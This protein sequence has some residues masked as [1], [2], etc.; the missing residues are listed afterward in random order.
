MYLKQNH[1]SR[2]LHQRNSY[3]RQWFLLDEHLISC[4]KEKSHTCLN[5]LVCTDIFHRTPVR[6]AAFFPL[7]VPFRLATMKQESHVDKSLLIRWVSNVEEESISVGKPYSTD[8]TPIWLL[9]GLES[10]FQQDCSVYSTL[11]CTHQ[12]APVS[13]GS[14]R[15][16]CFLWQQCLARWVLHWRV[17]LE[18][19]F[20]VSH[21]TSSRQKCLRIFLEKS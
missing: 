3:E 9:I 14:E 7:F 8:N 2:A 12:L 19:Y 21:L 11:D 16:Q 1:I 4:Q 5:S 17:L 18:P 10:D 20:Y 13:S 15:S 6:D